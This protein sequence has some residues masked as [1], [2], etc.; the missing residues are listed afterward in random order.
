MAEMVE[1]LDRILRDLVEDKVRKRLVKVLNKYEEQEEVWK[2]VVKH[3]WHTG[4]PPRVQFCCVYHILTSS[5]IYYW[6]EARQHGI[7]LLSEIV[8]GVANQGT[9]FVIDH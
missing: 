1:N 3:Q 5:V 4:L 9:A 2:N 6:T 8:S 7:Y